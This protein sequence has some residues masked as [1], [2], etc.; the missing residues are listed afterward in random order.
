MVL[1]RVEQVLNMFSWG[2]GVNISCTEH[3]WKLKFSMQNHLTHISTIFEYWYASVNLD[4]ALYL[5]YGNV[6]RPVLK[7]KSATMIFFLKK[8]LF[9]SM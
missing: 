8:K 9:L 5:E 1:R 4:N 6:Y 2:E 3:N 7:N